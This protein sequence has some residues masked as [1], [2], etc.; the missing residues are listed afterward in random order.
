VYLPIYL[1]GYLPIY[2]K[3][4]K[5]PMLLYILTKNFMEVQGN[6]LNPFGIILFYKMMW[7]FDG[8]D[9]EYVYSYINLLHV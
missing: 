8:Q 3:K 5:I 7:W 4:M 9:V 6:I 2:R 1:I